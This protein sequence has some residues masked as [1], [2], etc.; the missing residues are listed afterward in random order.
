MLQKFRER[1]AKYLTHL[2]DKYRFTI[3]NDTTFESVFQLKLTGMNVLVYFGFSFLLIVVLVFLA[4][5]YTPLRD[6]LPQH[7]DPK[8]AHTI[9]LNAERL[10][11]LEKELQLRDQYFQR[12][13]QTLVGK[14]STAAIQPAKKINEKDLALYATAEDSMLRNEVERDERSSL[15][16]QKDK[17]KNKD[18]SSLQFF[19]PVSKGMITAKYN[20]GKRHFGVDIVAKANEGIMSVLE[21]TVIEAT[22]TLQ[23]GYII[24]IQHSNNLVSIYKHNSSLLKEI[25]SHVKAGETIAIIGNTGELSTGP[26]LHL[27]LWHNGAAINP[28]Q[29]IKF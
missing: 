18:L 13:L 29:Y 21:G 3:Y 16:F 9:H 24:Q 27:E 4:L 2:R 11:S 5:V 17:S 25:G 22:W 8:L 23:T 26:H 19:T 12:Y 14:D 6:F 28:E 20:I 1:K 10:D 15:A 7:F